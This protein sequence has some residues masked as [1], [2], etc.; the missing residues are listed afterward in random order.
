MTDPTR[1]RDQPALTQS[2]GLIWLVVGGIFTAIA[3]GVLIAL[4]QLPPPGVALVAAIIVAAL[5]A[6]MWLVRFIVRPGRRRLGLMAAGM[7]AIAAVS[8]AATLIVAGSGL[9]A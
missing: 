7:L 5:Y 2:S 1:M 8:L 4:V 6:G 9:S 3:L